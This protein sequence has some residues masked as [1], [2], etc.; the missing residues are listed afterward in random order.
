MTRRGQEFLT[1]SALALIVFAVFS[2]VLR[3]DFVAWDD[4]L[5]IYNNPN[6]QSL[7]SQ[8][9][10]WMLTDCSHARRYKP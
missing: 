9:L 4:N 3:A 8:H 2:P 7:D 6:I 5:N 1:A 10:R